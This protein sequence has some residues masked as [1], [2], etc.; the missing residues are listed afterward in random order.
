MDEEKKEA[1][2][3]RIAYR[4][5]EKKKEFIRIVNLTKETLARYNWAKYV[6]TDEDE[7]IWVFLN[8]PF[9]DSSVWNSLLSNFMITEE[10]AFILCGRVPK[11]EDDE[12]TPVRF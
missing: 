6:A 7:D 3:Q 4:E 12:P 11:W 8:K 1:Q 5:Q 10:Q 2:R 9:K